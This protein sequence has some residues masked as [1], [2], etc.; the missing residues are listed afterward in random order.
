MHKRFKAIAMAIIMAAFTIMGFLQ[1]ASTV[2]AA[3]ELTVNI[4]YHRYADDY[5]GWNIWSWIGG[6]EGASY[7]FNKE[8]DFG[9]VASYTLQLEDGVTEVGF[10]VRH[11]TA[12]NAWNL[13]DTNND[14]FMDVTKA[15]DG[16]L[17]IYVIQDDASFGYS[18]EEMSLAP[19]IME[20]SVSS[21]TAVDFRVTTPFDSTAADIASK[22]TVKDAAGTAYAVSGA[23]SPDGE[24]ATSATITLAE[25]LDLFKRYT[26]AF[27]GYGEIAV[28][29]VKVFSTPEFEE[30]YYYDGDDLGAVWSVDKT[31]F[32]V[33][34]PTA[35]EVVLNLYSAGVGTNLLENIPMTQDTKG[36]WVAQKAGDLNKTYYTYSV[37]VDGVTKEAVDP[38][39]KA[40]GVNGDR[41]MVI[42]LAST[43]PTGFSEDLRPALASPTDAVIYELHVRDFSIDKSSGMKNRGKYLAF[44][45]T[46]TKSPSGEK[47]GIDYLVDLGINVVHLNPAFDFASID[48]TKLVNNQFNWGYDPENYN[49][50]EGS[51]STD[52][53]HGEVR[54]N[55]YKQ[56][57]QSLHNNGIRV[58]MDVVYNHTAASADSNFNKIVPGYYYRLTNN[59]QFSNGSGCGN[60]TASERAMMRKFIVD[61]VVYWATEYHIDGFRFDLMGLHDAETMNAVREALNAIDPTI[62]VYG[63]GWTAG[64]TTLPG[65]RQVLKANMAS[66][67]TKIAAFSDDIR[68]GIKGSVFDS[69]DRGFAT[70][71][72]GMEESIK[73]GVI[74][75][76]ENSQVDYSLVNYSKAWWAA[77][78]TQTI[79]YASAHD[80]NT[81]WDKICTSNA[82]DSQEDRIKMNLLSGAIVFTSQGIPFFLAGEEFLRSKPAEDGSGFVDNSYNSPDSVNSL[83]WDSVAANKEVYNYY[84]GLIAFR[85]AHSALRMTSTADIQSNLSFLTGLDP[86]VVAY[87]ISNSPNGETAKALCVIYNANK[88]AANVT[89]PE[90]DWNVYVKGNKAGTEILE[91]ISGGSVAVDPISALVLVQEDAKA[92]PTDVPAPTDAVR[93]TAPASA[94]EQDSNTVVYIIL[95]IAAAAVA[96]V[97]V[98]AVIRR[99]KA[100]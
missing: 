97:V 89:I 91:T 94:E 40:V 12:S 61:S 33:W 45:E 96:A 98:F 84:Q 21:P 24:K 49:A 80:N 28:S 66:V 30:A 77:A 100:K 43:D 16:V 14:R 39:A 8:D 27:E 73:F 87:T 83:K 36:T 50:P 22:I 13:K 59:G 56:M 18:A 65:D 93:T 19:K 72:A 15:K 1:P 79:S 62:I 71:K 64:A 31:D 9:K 46:G 38:Y 95:G 35:S 92:A 48:E 68:D 99:R 54:I 55:E 6:G 90:G 29:N 44:T 63:E 53:Q 74:A 76:T 37:T 20:A 57:V 25:P 70:G 10:I 51:Y 69:M 32:R 75:S 26:L 88:T 67:D 47:T 81:L 23:A 41:G 60:E 11:S 5:D 42:D 85:K 4:H 3:S 82:S 58:V 86:N 52:P 7:D 78:P 2:K 34:A 17:D